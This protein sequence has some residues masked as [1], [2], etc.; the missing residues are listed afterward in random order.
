[1]ACNEIAVCADINEPQFCWIIF[2][3]SFTRAGL[4]AIDVIKEIWALTVSLARINFP[5][6]AVDI[7]IYIK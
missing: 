4:D 6:E 5:S 3:S 1:M 7:L 2:P